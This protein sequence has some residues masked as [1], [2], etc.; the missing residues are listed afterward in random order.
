MA[1]VGQ[2]KIFNEAFKIAW[3]LTVENNKLAPGIGPKLSDEIRRLMK[4]G[5]TDPAAIAEQAFRS[6]S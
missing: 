6:I 5:A 1:I 4:N 2:I 3:D